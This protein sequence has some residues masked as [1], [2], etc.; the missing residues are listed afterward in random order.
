M[1]GLE[2]TQKIRSCTNGQDIPIIAVT[3]SAFDGDRT[4]VSESGMDDF[5]SK[6]FKEPGL[7][8]LIG[9]HTGVK[10]M[11]EEE[12]ENVDGQASESRL[13][14]DII[15]SMA[16]IPDN[17]IEEMREAALNGYMSRLGELLDDVSAID[18]GVSAE[19]RGLAERYEYDA[20]AGVL[21]IKGD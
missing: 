6:P 2:A 7:F 3:A 4:K 17:L 14:V 10:Y 12:E 13:R 15:H 9:K 1:D 19:L 11:Y 18:D 8:D 20:L 21:E 16:S 5:L